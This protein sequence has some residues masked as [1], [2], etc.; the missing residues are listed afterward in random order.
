MSGIGDISKYI[1]VTTVSS[2]DGAIMYS[3]SSSFFFK[4]DFL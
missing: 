2:I 1:L 3:S 4:I